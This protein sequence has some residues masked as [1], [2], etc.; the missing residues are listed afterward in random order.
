MPVYGSAFYLLAFGLCKKVN[1]FSRAGRRRFGRRG[2]RAGTNER[3]G[4]HSMRPRV[5]FVS[6]GRRQVGICPLRE[7]LDEKTAEKDNLL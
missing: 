2:Q 4:Q 3:V 1:L 5:A 6:H 7:R